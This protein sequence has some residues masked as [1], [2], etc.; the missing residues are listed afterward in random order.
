M[1]LTRSVASVCERVPACARSPGHPTAPIT[2]P[3]SA[4]A[5]LVIAV[6]CGGGGGIARTDSTGGDPVQAAVRAMGGADALLGIQFEQI[7]AV[8]QRFEPGQGSEPGQ[9]P[10]TMPVS[11]FRY[12]A[13]DD[14]RADRFRMEWERDVRYPYPAKLAY[15]VVV[16]DRV[17]FVEGRD[18]VFSP[19]RA[20]MLPANVAT[21][22]KARWL[23]SPDLV[24]AEALRHP[25]NVRSEPDERYRGRNHHVVAMKVSDSA[26][27]IRIFLD[28]STA[29]PAKID[30]L[31]DDPIYGDALV[32]VELDDWREASG[33]R[34]PFK[35]THKVA[36]NLVQTEQRSSIETHTEAPSSSAFE[37]AADSRPAGGGGDAALGGRSSQWFLRMH[38]Y[39]IPHYDRHLPVTMTD[40]AP[41]VVH[42]TGSTHHSLIV[43]ME[44]HLVVIEAPLYEER[45][46]AVMARIAK[47]WPNKPIRTV[48]VT[49][50]HDDHTGG[51]RAYAAAGAAVVTS[52]A[53]RKA[54][55]EYLRAPHSVFPDP[56]QTSPR[57]VPIEVVSDHRTLGQG[58]RILELY[59]VPNSHSNDMLAAYL[60][61]H[62]FLF[63]SDIY[64]PGAGPEPFKVYNREL[65]TFI[66]QSGLA[67]ERLGGT[68]GGVG[69][70]EDLRSFVGQ[71]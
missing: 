47:R 46:K 62:R 63:V 66:E 42:V 35:I 64:S 25:E 16:V 13:I 44:D 33:L 4:V 5:A 31:E 54:V 8:G 67:V 22:R 61:Q 52:Q 29:L 24:L 48:V 55:E 71:K 15:A 43:E 7:T 69:S 41:G 57:E 45:S 27:P 34:F 53:N 36:G 17:G 20:A 19:P 56:L 11:E 14:R 30:S 23:T 6:G 37:I 49:H 12:R 39:G 26:R 68:H 50:F 2:K 60:P 40:V 59:R 1:S 28:A 3:R 9:Q 10:M 21:L 32:E 58:A 65:L 51:L 38:A 70:L 18:G